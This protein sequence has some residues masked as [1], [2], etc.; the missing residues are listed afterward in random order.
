MI[1]L[2]FSVIVWRWKAKVQRSAHMRFSFGIEMRHLMLALHW[3]VF[4]SR[5]AAQRVWLPALSCTGP[6]HGLE[7]QR[8]QHRIPAP[9]GLLPLPQELTVWHLVPL[10]I[11]RNCDYS[12]FL[13]YKH[14]LNVPLSDSVQVAPRSRKRLRRKEKKKRRVPIKPMDLVH[15][16]PSPN[17]C[18]RNENEGILGTRGMNWQREGGILHQLTK[19][20]CQ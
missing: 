10:I 20:E 2:I 14:H 12:S 16:E 15:T 11:L 6:D 8:F 1:L 7:A 13:F 3:S 5:E 19:S 18:L 9:L 17:F 4:P